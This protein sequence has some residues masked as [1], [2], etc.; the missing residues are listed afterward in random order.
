MP[1][2]DHIAITT[3]EKARSQDFV[4]AEAMLGRVLADVLLHSNKTRHQGSPASVGAEIVE[5]QVLGLQVTPNGS[6]VDIGVGALL[7]DSASLSPVPGTYDSSYRIAHNRSALTVAAPAPGSDTYYLLEVQM[8]ED[9][10]TESRKV[11]NTSTN[12]FS[13][14][15]VDKVKLRKIQS[16]WIA[17]S[18]TQYPNPTGGNWVPL[19]A[20]FRPGGGGAVDF[21]DIVDIRRLPGSRAALGD[22]YWPQQA[23]QVARFESEQIPGGVSANGVRFSVQEATSCDVTTGQDAGGYKMNAQYA[24]GGAYLDL[25]DASV[26]TPGLSIVADTWYY[27]YLCPWNGALPESAYGDHRVRGVLVLSDSR[28]TRFGHNTATITLPAPW[29]NYAVPARAAS[30][31]GAVK[32]KSDNLGWGPQAGGGGFQVLQAPNHDLGN[33]AAS[34]FV[35]TQTDYPGHAKV[36]RMAIRLQLTVG[37]PQEVTFSVGARPTGAGTAWSDIRVTRWIDAVFDEEFV[38]DVP[39]SGILDV[40]WS[41]FTGTATLADISA[42]LTGYFY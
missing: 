7:Q 30:C 10:A 12:T 25:T 4:N 37:S 21:P 32:R 15:V 20:V 42:R 35:L 22:R 19:A 18:A 11:L 3:L 14:T 5:N 33:S 26:I 1:G 6:G 24:V 2:T 13:D 23:P 34:P 28:P 29:G 16:Q 41:L 9:V 17:G 38:V 31:I 36:L 8:V 27:L 40:A 39:N